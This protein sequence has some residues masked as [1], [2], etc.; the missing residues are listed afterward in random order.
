MRPLSSVLRCQDPVIDDATKHGN[1]DVAA[2][3]A[4]VIYAAIWTLDLV[5][6]GVVPS[7]TT[8]A[9]LRQYS[10]QTGDHNL[11]DELLWPFPFPFYGVSP[12]LNV[13]IR[14]CQLSG[15]RS[16]YLQPQSIPEKFR[17]MNK[18]VY[19]ILCGFLFSRKVLQR[20]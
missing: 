5:V 20:H 19:H 17:T 3:A 7:T 13:A 11:Y 1:G 14:L 15:I 8:G 18:N 10:D 6:F 12:A 4:I 9:R 16:A 2:H